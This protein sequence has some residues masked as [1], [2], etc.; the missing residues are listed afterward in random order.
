M[1]V[2]LFVSS[3]CVCVE[4]DWPRGCL[5]FSVRL[6]Q[7]VD[8]VVMRDVVSA[9]EEE[10]AETDVVGLE[11]TYGGRREKER[12]RRSRANAPRHTVSVCFSIIPSETWQTQQGVGVFAVRAQRLLLEQRQHAA[13]PVTTRTTGAP[14]HYV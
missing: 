5:C 8:Y 11:G 12:G 14:P 13:K 4:H 1:D 6:E 7:N 10:R 3:V 9:G 2:S